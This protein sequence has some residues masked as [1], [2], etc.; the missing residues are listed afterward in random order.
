M[1][2]WQGDT[3]A[4]LRLKPFLPDRERLYMKNLKRLIFNTKTGEYFGQDGWTKDNERA[5]HFT[6]MGEVLKLEA[7]YH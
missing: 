1:S 7:P 3:E 5:K 4:S 2:C 6:N